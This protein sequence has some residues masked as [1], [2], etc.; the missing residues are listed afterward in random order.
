MA[1]KSCLAEI[2][3][4]YADNAGWT[5]RMRMIEADDGHEFR[6]PSLTSSGVQPFYHGLSEVIGM[7]QAKE[8]WCGYLSGG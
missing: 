5:E 6:H 4:P 1:D 7:Q 2:V 8:S 3:R